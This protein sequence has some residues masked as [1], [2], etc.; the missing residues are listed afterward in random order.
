MCV[1]VCVYIQVSGVE[2]DGTLF[3][4]VNFIFSSFRVIFLVSGSRW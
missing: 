3:I 2:D 1:C 4:I